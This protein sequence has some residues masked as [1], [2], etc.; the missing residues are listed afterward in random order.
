[1]KGHKLHVRRKLKEN[2]V[3]LK[4]IEAS[5]IKELMRI[6]WYLFVSSILELSLFSL[7][8][9][10]TLRVFLEHSNIGSR[11]A[12]EVPRRQRKAKIKQRR[13]GLSDYNRITYRYRVTC[14]ISLIFFACMV[15]ACVYLVLF[16]SLAWVLPGVIVVF[17]LAF[18][19]P[20]NHGVMGFFHLVELD[21]QM[22]SKLSEV[23]L[24]KIT[25]PRNPWTEKSG[26]AVNPSCVYPC[27]A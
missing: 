2:N 13:V 21:F 4:K 18:P 20:D 3:K 25:R 17:I 10:W 11:K 7:S 27:W 12:K 15:Y 9:S 26:I 23:V 8:H 5:L 19:F 1:M 24:R 6:S 16:L 14:V 22:V